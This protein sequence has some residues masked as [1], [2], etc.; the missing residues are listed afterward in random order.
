ML[1]VLLLFLWL[2][3]LGREF[4]SGCQRHNKASSH[5]KRSN[6]CNI[7]CWP[8]L[9]VYLFCT[10]Y[11]GFPHPIVSEAPSG[12]PDLPQDLRMQAS[13]GQSENPRKALSALPQDP[14]ELPQG[15]TGSSG[16][17]KKLLQSHQNSFPKAH[18]DCLRTIRNL[19]RGGPAEFPW[20]PRGLL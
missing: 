11:P 2:E 5:T 1:L 4:R 15:H 18:Q 9:V 6:T 10:P 12:L 20:D 7:I 13:Q 17:P 19:N 8:K 16:P 3:A 14:R